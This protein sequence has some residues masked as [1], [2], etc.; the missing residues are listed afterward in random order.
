MVREISQSRRL[1]I[2]DAADRPG[3]FPTWVLEQRASDANWYGLY[4]AER[5]IREHIWRRSPVARP[6]FEVVG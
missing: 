6:P 3:L 2:L 1:D 5:V 4:E